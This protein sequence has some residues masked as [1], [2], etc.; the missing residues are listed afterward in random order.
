VPATSGHP[1]P[2]PDALGAGAVPG[3]GA[4]WLRA[5]CPCPQ[6][7][8]PGSGQRLV[9]LTDLPPGGRVTAVTPEG[10]GL[11]VTFGPD[12]HQAVFSRSWLARQAAPGADE[13]TEDGKRLWTAAD[14]GGVPPAWSWA[15]YRASAQ[16][17]A[18]C[19]ASVLRDGLAVLRGVPRE[20]GAV[21]TVAQTMGYVRE[22]NY[23]R[24]F[25]VRV[26][27]TP[28]N[29]AFT[30]LPIAPHTDNPYRDPVPTVQLL[31]CLES[32][33][34]GGDSGL[35]DGFM[36][37]G[38]LRAADPDAFALLAATPVTFAYAD[39]TA[40]LSATRPIIGT[41]P[42]G[43]VREVRFNNRSMRPWRP[44]GPALA[45]PAL[46]DPVAG[47]EAFD[48]AGRAFAEILARPA[49]MLTFRL[50]PGDCMVFDNT[51]VLHARTGFA[52]AGSRHLQ[53]C[54]A[55]LDGVSS[56]LAV[57]RREADHDQ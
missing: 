25:D 47:A 37:A 10:D 12:G 13:R 23:G 20:P 38:L 44:A 29:L 43:R 46:A 27:A 34:A 56:A 3:F 31:H 11:R 1:A 8:D 18:D 45:G 52:A 2:A 50:E 22:T 7:R 16:A 24:L 33:V 53:G 30:G 36:A 42:A 14:L 41:D 6:C 28:S 17:R 39:A 40:A 32:A 49:L 26:T 57:L 51:R 21:L 55:D 4:S 15:E 54:Y 9:S 48:A 5:N 35:V 19:L